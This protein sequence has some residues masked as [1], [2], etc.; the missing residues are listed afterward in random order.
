[1]E[2]PPQRVLGVV[3]VAV[4]QPSVEL[5]CAMATPVKPVGTLVCVVGKSPMVEPLV[6]ATVSAKFLRQGMG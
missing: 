3:T 2:K 4:C 6:M 5:S 1:M